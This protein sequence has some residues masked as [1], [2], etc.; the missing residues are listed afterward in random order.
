[1]K[2]AAKFHEIIFYPMQVGY[3]SSSL[4]QALMK[5]EKAFE[6]VFTEETHHSRWIQTIGW[7]IDSISS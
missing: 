2:Q 4:L 1:M 5:R 3:S 6:N 7:L